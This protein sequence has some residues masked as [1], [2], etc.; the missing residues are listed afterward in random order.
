MTF[1]AKVTF[2]EFVFLQGCAGTLDPPCFFLA[3]GLR[4]LTL[5]LD[6]IWGPRN[7][8]PLMHDIIIPSL[9]FEILLICDCLR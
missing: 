4:P 1:Y 8:Y 3:K 5:R 9:S 7:P 6:D 2:W